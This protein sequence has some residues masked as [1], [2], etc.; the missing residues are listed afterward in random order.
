MQKKELN[1]IAHPKR[2]YVR[3]A[4]LLNNIRYLHCQACGVDDQTVVGA[5]SNSSAHGK[6]RSIKADDNMVAALCWDCHHALDQGHYLNKEEKEQFWLE[7]HLRT[8]Y[9]LIKA[10]LYPKDV[11]LPKTYLDWQ[12]GLN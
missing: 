4:K 1:L 11:P 8:I 9:N 3:S 5:H 7:A 2:Q 12:N 10:D 6:G